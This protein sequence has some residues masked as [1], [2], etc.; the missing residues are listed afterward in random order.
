MDAMIMFPGAEQLHDIRGLDPISWWPLASGWWLVFLGCLFLL[1]LVLWLLQRL[2]PNRWR[3]EARA[4][5]RRLRRRLRSEDP[6]LVL[7][8]FSEL[9]RRIAMARHGRDRCAG[10]AGEEWLR[11]LSENDPGR[12]DWAGRAPWLDELPYAPP[13]D[14]PK[15]A[16]LRAT[17]EAA[18]TWT[19]P[20]P[21]ERRW[22]E[23]GRLGRW[24]RSR[25][26]AARRPDR[27]AAATEASAANV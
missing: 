5:L 9:L 18:M 16:E 4:E 7:E 13:G 3:W 8:Q 1:A 25:L 6:R 23:V 24:L 2:S 17:I 21:Q 26:P 11:W 27:E 14:E 20:L 10:L 19:A 15:P 12:F 22:R